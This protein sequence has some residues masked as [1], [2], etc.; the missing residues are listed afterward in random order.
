MTSHNSI[1]RFPSAPVGPYGV[2]EGDIWTMTGSS[3]GKLMAEEHPNMLGIWEV[4]IKDGVLGPCV[5]TVDVT[6]PDPGIQDL[7]AKARA[8]DEKYMR[9]ARMR[10]L[11]E[12]SHPDWERR[13]IVR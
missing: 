5:Y 1:Q 3:V 10:E 6:N 13:K 2:N 12:R 8:G 11:W 9:A 4:M 7:I